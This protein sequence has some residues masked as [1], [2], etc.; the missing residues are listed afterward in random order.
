M[1]ERV[2]LRERLLLPL[3]VG[4]VV[5]W[6]ERG[7]PCGSGAVNLDAVVPLVDVGAVVGDFDQFGEAGVCALVIAEAVTRAA[8]EGARL[9]WNMVHWVPPEDG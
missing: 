9:K 4:T 2:D 1:H 8:T 6:R 5:R 3:C 7:A